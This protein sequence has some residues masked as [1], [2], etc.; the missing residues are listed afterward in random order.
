[1]FT[2]PDDCE[3][4]TSC[5]LLTVSHYE[6]NVFFLSRNADSFERPLWN[7]R[8]FTSRIDEDF[9]NTEL[10][11]PIRMVLND[12]VRI[13]RAHSERS[14]ARGTLAIASVSKMY[15]LK[16]RVSEYRLGS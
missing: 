10:P 7:P 8:I 2:D 9:G 3:A 4:N 16:G 13:K 15:L 14:L 12:A 5:D 11:L 1:M 6:R